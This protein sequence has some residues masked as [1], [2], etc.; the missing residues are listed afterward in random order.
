VIM[1]AVIAEEPPSLTMT[2]THASYHGAI[3]RGLQPLHQAT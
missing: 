3:G 2:K 1:A